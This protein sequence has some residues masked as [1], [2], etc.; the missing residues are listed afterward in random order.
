MSGNET[1][2]ATSGAVW[3]KASAINPSGDMP[4]NAASPVSEINAVKA[5]RVIIKVDSRIGAF[6]TRKA[7]TRSLA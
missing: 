2:L 4:D 6:G 1:G 3:A 5:R 7:A